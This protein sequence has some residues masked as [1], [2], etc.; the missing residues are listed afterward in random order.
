[1]L[2]YPH[3]EPV[4]VDR[5]DDQNGVSGQNLLTLSSKGEE[6]LSTALRQNRELGSQK[7]LE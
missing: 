6:T 7:H 1:M 2:R 3:T 5:G 4:E